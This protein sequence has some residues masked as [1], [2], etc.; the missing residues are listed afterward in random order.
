[1]TDKK[2][3]C[4]MCEQE[5]T[6]TA[7]EQNWYL[8]HSLNDPKYC[9]TCREERKNQRNKKNSYDNSEQKAA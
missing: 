2:I 8:E 1:M 5:F 9:K 6:F 4:K 3:I 7:G